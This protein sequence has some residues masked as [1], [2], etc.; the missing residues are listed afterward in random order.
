VAYRKRCH[1]INLQRDKEGSQKG[2]E[3][4]GLKN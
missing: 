2:T 3:I 1:T 4:Q